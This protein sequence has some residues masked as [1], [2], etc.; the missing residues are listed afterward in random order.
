MGN[1]AWS[2][3]GSRQHDLRK[4]Y[5]AHKAILEAIKNGDQENAIQLVKINIQES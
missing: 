5:Q 3:S 2:R 1:S 4:S